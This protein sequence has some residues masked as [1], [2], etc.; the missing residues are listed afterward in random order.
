MSNPLQE[1]QDQLRYIREGKWVKRTP[2]E[3]GEACLAFAC[4]RRSYGNGAVMVQTL[5]PGAQTLVWEAIRDLFPNS[6]LVRESVFS[7]VVLWNDK[8]WRKLSHV[9]AVLVLAE[10]LAKEATSE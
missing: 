2:E 3:E 1:I 6:K 8:P 7:E 5:G 10:T 9:E 4:Q